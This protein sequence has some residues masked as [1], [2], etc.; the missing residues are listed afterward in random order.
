MSE[1]VPYQAPGSITQTGA[2]AA[3]PAL[4]ADAGEDAVRRFL[5]FFAATIR[6]K[7]TRVAYYN[8]IR[9][10]FAW[11]ERRGIDGLRRIEPIHVAL[12]IEELQ[13]S[14][15]NRPSSSTWRPCACSLIGL[16]QVR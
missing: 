8:D 10:F 1:I 12:Y 2:E 6:N 3:V 13:H 7:N 16:S 5:E 15:P 11:C 9:Q 14:F 4:V